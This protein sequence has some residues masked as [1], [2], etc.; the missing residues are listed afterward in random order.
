MYTLPVPCRHIFLAEPVPQTVL[1]ALCS[2]TPSF[3]PHKNKEA[4]SFGLLW[5]YI[6]ISTSHPAGN[7]RFIRLSIVFGVGSVTSMSRLCTR[8][9]NC[10]RP[11]LYTCGLFTTV[12]VLRSVGSGIG[13]AMVAPVR[14]AVSTICF[15]AWSITLWS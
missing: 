9:S 7:D 14:S 12:N 13:P 4:R 8:I 6:L 5:Y 2:Y 1:A 10:S 11:F 15:A 3:V